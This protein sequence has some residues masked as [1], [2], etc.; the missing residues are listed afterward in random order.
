[1]GNCIVGLKY[2]PIN[3]GN[4]E[5]RLLEVFWDLKKAYNEKNIEDLE[6]IHDLEKQVILVMG[7]A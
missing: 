3:N 6:K 7:A 2:R 4:T 5:E 1:M